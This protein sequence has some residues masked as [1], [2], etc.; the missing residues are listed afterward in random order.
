MTSEINYLISP[1]K[2][3]KE[4]FD[5][6]EL[7]LLT[8]GM[9]IYIYEAM[10]RLHIRNSFATT[11]I[12][13][14]QFKAW[15]CLLV[16]KVFFTDVH[17]GEGDKADSGISWQKWCIQLMLLN[18][19]FFKYMATM[20]SPFFAIQNIIFNIYVVCCIQSVAYAMI[21]INFLINIYH[22]F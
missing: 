2:P 9:L 13:Y 22:V 15:Q 21:E 6:P 16:Y 5:S 14:I 4:N 12:M 19:T 18:M 11:I 7:C 20:S 8:Y 17:A 3:Q 1:M 10:F